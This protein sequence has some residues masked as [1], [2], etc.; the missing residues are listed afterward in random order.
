MNQFRADLHENSLSSSLPPGRGGWQQGNMAPVG[1][2]NNRYRVRRS[3]LRVRDGLLEARLWFLRKIMKMDIH[4]TV[5]I[6]LK[7]NID[8]TN[9]S[10]VHID[11]GTYIAFHAVVLAH[12]MSRLLMVD[13]YIG[14]N[15]FIGA[16]S[17]IMPGVRVGDE[18]IVGS[19]S[20]VTSDV[21]SHSV[22]A[23]NPAK[24][25]RSGIRTRRWGILEDAYAKAEAIEPGA[26]AQSTPPEGD[27]GIARFNTTSNTV[28][29]DKQAEN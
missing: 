18:C 3:V 28:Q 1:H 5:K 22:V 12:D 19:G 9:P 2:R 29:H 13:T 17:I 8:L 20:V 4:P 21:P 26:Q 15:C 6:S 25:I 11:E 10:G 24:I 7:A 16:N 23:G 14:K 27:G